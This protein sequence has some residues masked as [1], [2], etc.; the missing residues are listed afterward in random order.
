MDFYKLK[1]KLQ[2]RKKQLKGF[3]TLCKYNYYHKFNLEGDDQ[4]YYHMQRQLLRDLIK[5]R[6]EQEYLEEHGLLPE[7]PEAE[8]E[9]EPEIEPAVEPGLLR[10]FG[11]FDQMC[12]AF[13]IS[14]TTFCVEELKEFEDRT[15]IAVKLLE[16]Y[17]EEERVERAAAP[18]EAGAR[19]DPVTLD[20]ETFR[21]DRADGR[22]RPLPVVCEDAAQAAERGPVRMVQELVLRVDKALAEEKLSAQCLEYACQCSDAGYDWCVLDNAHYPALYELQL[23]EGNTEAARSLLMDLRF[24]CPHYCRESGLDR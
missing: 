5:A 11:F 18:H 17:G 9:A 2:F 19:Y 23:A 13:S 10:S 6:P 24:Y 16:N 12:F 20:G 8:P 7:E 4:F 1:W 14:G 15:E 22:L 21:W 3:F